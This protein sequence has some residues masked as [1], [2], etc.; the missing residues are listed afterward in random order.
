MLRGQKL[1]NYPGTA[2]WWTLT[3][4]PGSDKPSGVYAGGGAVMM[5]RVE[6][7]VKVRTE[8]K[9]LAVYPLDGCGN[10]MAKLDGKEATRES[11]TLRIHLA[12]ETPWYEIAAK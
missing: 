4:A 2:D 12:S 1:V 7:V 8:V 5:E 9:S 10:R 11:G 3:P 6:C